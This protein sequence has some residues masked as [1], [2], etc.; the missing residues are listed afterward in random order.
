MGSRSAF[1]KLLPLRDYS[2]NAGSSRIKETIFERLG[3]NKHYQSVIMDEEEID[4]T[5]IPAML[6]VQKAKA[7]HDSNRYTT[8]PSSIAESARRTMIE[9]EAGPS[10]RSK[11]K[12]RLEHDEDEV[13]SPLISAEY[14]TDEE[15]LGTLSSQ[16]QDIVATHVEV[17]RRLTIAWPSHQ[18]FATNHPEQ[19]L[20]V[21]DKLNQLATGL[22]LLCQTLAPWCIEGTFD[23]FPVARVDTDGLEGI[24]KSGHGRDSSRGNLHT[25]PIDQEI[26]AN[27]RGPHEDYMLEHPLARA[28]RNSGTN[29]DYRPRHSEADSSLRDIHV[30][31]ESIAQRDSAEEYVDDDDPPSA[32]VQEL[33]ANI[34]NINGRFTGLE[35][36]QRQLE[37][38]LWAVDRVL[39]SQQRQAI[40]RSSA[41]QAAQVT[42]Q[43]RSTALR[44]RQPDE[45]SEDSDKPTGWRKYWCFSIT[46]ARAG[47]RRRR[48]R[49]AQHWAY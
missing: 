46:K 15:L 30:P 8:E 47:F 7:A 35:N 19:Y 21:A 41:Q 40:R 43:D 29:N 37:R 44:E 22:E 20:Q 36:Q 17:C 2:A 32:I 9:D 26:S 13:D 28:L 27:D 48:T 34:H 6:R 1:D 3:S 4:L 33:W 10:T 23:V 14:D 49:A 25:N 12:A 11:G 31:H 24:R 18:E 45:V 16:V 39:A 5:M 42:Q 38:R